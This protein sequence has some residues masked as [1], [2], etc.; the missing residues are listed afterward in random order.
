M[1]IN[2]PNALLTVV[3]DET[4]PTMEAFPEIMLALLKLELFVTT[5][6][7]PVTV[8]VVSAAV[9]SRFVPA[10]SLVSAEALPMSAAAAPGAK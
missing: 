6:A 3:S 8:L 10:P 1:P 7:T 4:D 5:D 2:F 9:L